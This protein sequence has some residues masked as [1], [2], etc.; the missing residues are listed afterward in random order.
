VRPDA[1]IDGKTRSG[2]VA[3]TNSLSES[4][5]PAAWEAIK[6]QAK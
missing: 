1:I 2:D 3:A 6:P 5:N 4:N